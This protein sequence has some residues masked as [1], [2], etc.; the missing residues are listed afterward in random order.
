MET[1]MET[2]TGTNEQ[3]YYT[4]QNVSLKEFK[5]HDYVYNLGIVNMPKIVDYNKKTKEMKM[6]RVGVMNVSDF[7]GAEAKNISEELFG[8]IRSIIQTL[9]DHNI[10][11]ID[12]TGYN[13]IE[14][15][16]KIWIIDFEHA[17][18]NNANAKRKIKNKFVERFLAGANEWNPE[19]A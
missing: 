18:H 17:K 3:L 5:I 14:T 10:L 1:E 12:I 11:Y 13:F 15:D 9:Y 7:Y 4:K 19:F 6:E 8:R 16:D 2:E